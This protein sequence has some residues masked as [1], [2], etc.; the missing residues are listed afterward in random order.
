MRSFSRWQRKKKR[1]RKTDKA[2]FG[3]R[4]RCGLNLI[5]PLTYWNRR[6]YTLPSMHM[7]TKE[8]M[9]SSSAVR[10]FQKASI[11]AVIITSAA[12]RRRHLH[13]HHQPFTED[14]QRIIMRQQRNK[15]HFGEPLKSRPA[16]AAAAA[17]YVCAGHSRAKQ[18]VGDV[19]KEGNRGGTSCAG[20]F[21]H[22]VT[23]CRLYRLL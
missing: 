16:A 18:E 21:L 17:S 4:R 9:V 23:L 2:S 1:R 11:S 3:S 15:R 5:A 10:E 13:N 22:C 19:A 6:K 12:L 20:V 7:H 14:T 8:P